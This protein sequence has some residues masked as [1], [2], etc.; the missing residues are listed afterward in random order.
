[1]RAVHVEEWLAHGTMYRPSMQPQEDTTPNHRYRAITLANVR[2]H[3]L[4]QRLDAEQRRALSVVGEV[5]PFKVSPH[6]IENL[7]DWDAVP[8]D[9]IFQLVFPQSGMLAEAEFLA[10]EGAMRQAPDKLDEVRERI[11]DGLNPNPAGQKTMNVPYVRGIPFHGAQHKYPETLLFFPSAGQTCHAYCTFCFRW[12]QFVGHVKD[13]FRSNDFELLAE[14]LAVHPEITDLLITGGDPLV[15]STANLAK[16]LE[17][18]LANPALEHVQSIRIGT[19]SLAFWPQRFV[20]DPDADA[21]LR[22]FE[23]VRASGRML[24]VMAHMSHPRELEPEVAQLAIQ[25]IRA[26]GAVI[27]MQSPCVRHVND[28][29][30]TW[31]EL[32]RKGVRLGCVPYYF[33]VERDTGARRWFELPLARCH[34]IFRDAYA[35]VSGLARTVRGPSMSATPGKVH[36][37]GTTRVGD[38][39]AFVLQYLQCRRPE[40]VRRPFFA[41]FDPVATWFDQLQPLSRADAAYFPQWW[42]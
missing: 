41:R 13:R 26:T 15:M 31:A 21:L 34:Q 5:L 32:W 40:L 17:P 4:W 24:S 29:A 36:I 8:A 33:F 2:S 38:E 42:P 14:Y 28:D 11:R 16:Y 27:R 1:M 7:I 23:K 22:L 10:V 19:K 39:E 25:R 12:P 30:N 9:P 35:A 6:V 37:L 18:L 3:P 20:H